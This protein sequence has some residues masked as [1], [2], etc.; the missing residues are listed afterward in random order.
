MKLFGADVEVLI[1]E[2]GKIKQ[3]FFLDEKHHHE[4]RRKRKAKNSRQ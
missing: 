1:D 4:D 2:K 3:I